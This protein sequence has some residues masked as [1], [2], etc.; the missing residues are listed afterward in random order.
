MRAKPKKQQ[1]HENIINGVYFLYSS[2]KTL[3]IRPSLLTVLQSTNSIS[4]QVEALISASNM[5]VNEISEIP[6]YEQ[7][8]EDV[9]NYHEIKTEMYFNIAQMNKQKYEEE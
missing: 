2:R 7:M 9:K 5:E 3:L 6:E 4:K 8:A 1:I